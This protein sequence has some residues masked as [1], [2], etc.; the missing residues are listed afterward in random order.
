M[1]LSIDDGL[2]ALARADLHPALDGLEDRVWAAVQARR[3]NAAGG[4]GMRAAVTVAALA[5]GLVFGAVTVARPPHLSEMGLLSEDGLLTPSV[6][7]G[8]GV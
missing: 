7:L 1:P 2:N 3:A 5:L 8:G 4:A 6:R